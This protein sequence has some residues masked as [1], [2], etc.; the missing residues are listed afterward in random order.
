MKVN[1]GVDVEA[2]AD[3]DTVLAALIKEL[4]AS[5]QSPV[6]TL[7]MY[8]EVGTGHGTHDLY[9]ESASKSALH[10]FTRG[11]SKIWN[12]FYEWRKPTRDAPDKWN[13]VILRWSDNHGISVEYGQTDVEDVRGFAARRKAWQKQEFGTEDIPFFVEP[14]KKKIGS[15]C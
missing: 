3:K 12:H 14:R 1:T 11:T 4:I 5:L 15:S 2:E 13:L 9:I 6:R 7:V 10:Y 8:M